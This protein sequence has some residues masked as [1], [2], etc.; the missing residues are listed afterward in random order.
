M[1]II[2]TPKFAALTPVKGIFHKEQS[3]PK[4]QPTDLQNVH[5]VFVK[6]F[7]LDE[8]EGLVADITADDYY[9]LYINGRLACMG[10]APSNYFHQHYNRIDLSEYF[11]VGENVIAMHVY[12]QGLINRAYGSGD[13]RCMMEFVLRRNDGETIIEDCETVLESDASWKYAYDEH[14]VAG[15]KIGYDTAFLENL[16]FTKYDPS[17]YLGESEG[18]A[19]VEIRSDHKFFNMCT[20][21]VATEIIA[22]DTVKQVSDNEIFVD[23]GK[24]YV[25]YP[26]V[27]LRGRR[28]QTVTLLCGEECEGD[29]PTRARAQ[30][31]CNCNYTEVLT[32]SGDLDTTDFFEYKAFRYM[33]LICDDA[34]TVIKSIELLARFAEYKNDGARLVGGSQLIREI[35]ELC[36]HTAHYATQEGFL[37]CPSR[38]KGQYLGDFTV[39]G[40]AH[41][42]LTGNQYMYLKALYDFKA[43]CKIC[44]G[45]MAVA[46]GSFMQ[47]IA[48][49]SLQFP[50]QVLNYVE[51]TGDVDTAKDLYPTVCG[52]LEHFAQYEREDGLLVGIADKWNLVDWPENLRDGY[53]EKLTKP[54]APDSLHNVINAF[55]IGANICA[56][57]LAEIVGIAREKRSVA[58]V[59]AFNDVF[60]NRELGIYTDT[61]TSTHTALHS[62]VLP[63]F[64][65]F[66]PDELR[67]AIVCTVKEKGLNCGVQFSYFVLG[68]MSRLGA[69]DVEYALITSK[70]EHSW[71]NMLSEGATTLFEAWGKDQKWNT[72]LCHPWASAPIIALCR[73]AAELKQ[74]DPELVVEGGV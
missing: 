35:W 72:S 28:G 70:G 18:E 25:G 68:A 27:K 54:I 38:E 3:A 58:L 12:Y 40:L 13:N 19:A 32:L 53:D 23:F 49:F 64:Y 24:E 52:I 46:P 22:P 45:M 43:S 55:Y 20:T 21:C 29:N 7:T 33:T 69:Y 56:E 31:R 71:Y 73:D 2:T 66:A 14:Y 39:S 50:L 60:I 37:D 63:A 30:M 15:D 62:V 26:L 74:F 11:K 41:L 17:L 1:A 36:E 59:A 9:K 34:S 65:G 44:P 61:P 4:H 16:D 6:K 42:Y 48:D 67:D 8:T 51:Y 5:T 57:K 10:P 47:E